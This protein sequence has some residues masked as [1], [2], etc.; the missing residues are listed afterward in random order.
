[1]VWGWAVLFYSSP[2]AFKWM[3]AQVLGPRRA[4]FTSVASCVKPL[5]RHNVSRL[6]GCS[7][8]I[9]WQRF[10]NHQIRNRF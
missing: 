8:Y 9:H 1:M 3:D 2:P 10:G 5:L 6:L 4:M 7:A